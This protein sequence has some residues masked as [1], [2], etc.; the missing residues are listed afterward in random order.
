MDTVS[1]RDLAVEEFDTTTL[2]AHASQQAIQRRY[3]DFLIVDVDGHHYETASFAQIAEFIEDPVMRDQAK[4]QGY[5]GSGI[6]SGT[7]AYQELGG[8]VTRY[9]G[10]R[11]E[12]T[13]PGI[14]RDLTL[15]RRWMN[16][17][18]IDT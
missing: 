14:H 12:K 6:T 3:E 18:G 17:M 2:L 9:P 5:G 4:Y 13:P 1:Y 15:T 8:R 7:G 10:R 16:A 11:K